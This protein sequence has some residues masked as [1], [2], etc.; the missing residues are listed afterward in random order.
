LTTNKEKSRPTKYQ[1]VKRRVIA[2]EEQEEEEERKEGFSSDSDNDMEDGGDNVFDFEEGEKVGAAMVQRAKS[3]GSRK[4]YSSKMEEFRKFCRTK[5]LVWD[6]EREARG[7]PLTAPEMAAF[8]LL[9]Q[10]KTDQMRSFSCV[11]GYRSGLAHWYNTQFMNGVGNAHWDPITNQFCM[12]VTNIL[13]GYKLTVAEHKREGVMKLYEG[14]HPIGWEAYVYLLRMLVKKVPHADYKMLF[15]T[16]C[17]IT[18]QWSCLS[19]ANMIGKL[20]INHIGMAQDALTV[21]ISKHK[22]DQD[23]SKVFPRHVYA[24]PLNPVVCPFLHLGLYLFSI[25]WLGQGPALFPHDDKYWSDTVRRFLNKSLTEEEQSK[26]GV[27]IQDLGTHSIRKG[28]ASHVSS[29]AQGPS[30]TNIDFRAGWSVNGTAQQLYKFQVRASGDHFCGRSLAGIHRTNPAFGALPPRFSKETLERIKES[31]WENMLGTPFSNVPVGMK[32]A[33]PFLFASVCFHHEWLTSN[34]NQAAPLWKLPVFSR[35]YVHQ[36]KGLVLWND[37]VMECKESDLQSTGVP[38]DNSI[39]SAVKA[40]PQTINDQMLRNFS[41]NGAIPINEQNLA[42]KLREVMMSAD[43]RNEVFGPAATS[44]GSVLQAPATHNWWALFKWEGEVVAARTLPFDF[45]APTES[46]SLAWNLYVH[47]NRKLLIRPLCRVPVNDIP[48]D[49][50][51]PNGK[52]I[53]NSVKWTK[54]KALMGL[55]ER[56]IRQLTV[57]DLPN[58]M[59]L[60]EGES[61]SKLDC[62]FKRSDALFAKAFDRVAA[63]LCDEQALNDKEQIRRRMQNS[64]STIYN[65]LCKKNKAPN[66]EVSTRPNK[67]HRTSQSTLSFPS[68]I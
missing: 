64:I 22:G 63:L 27:A 66:G 18:L 47:G 6:N 51:D 19:R 9:L 25:P 5:N 46:L 8:Y 48:L 49:R 28:A 20:S 3:A 44:G 58:N 33:L 42:A 14:K 55:I 59:L 40:L 13:R 32:K 52:I 45:V 43:F 60:Q 10:E 15:R 2:V 16:L 54:F 35:G 36:Y 37:T 50:R 4:I 41:I 29:Q 38:T 57:D 23:G 26:L 12:K 67:R 21:T 31:D 1:M 53:R 34:F 7:P 30:D 61:L 17:T 56:N 11:S 24:N 65:L 68:C 62:D 39:L